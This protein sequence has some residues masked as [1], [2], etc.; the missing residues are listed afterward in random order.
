M[1]PK[2]LHLFSF[3]P[4]HQPTLPSNLKVNPTTR[5]QILCSSNN[6]K[7]EKCVVLGH[8]VGRKMVEQ[9]QKETM[10]NS[11]RFNLP[12][13]FDDASLTNKEVST[14]FPHREHFPFEGSFV[15]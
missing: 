6:T 15:F 10:S 12:K 1:Y 11:I 14:S 4:M 7:G 8:M 13:T 5:P 2:C 9:K 3:G